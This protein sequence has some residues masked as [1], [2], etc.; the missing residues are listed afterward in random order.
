[1]RIAANT[2]GILAI[3]L[4]LGAGVPATAQSQDCR[5]EVQPG[6]T[7]SGIA[8]DKLGDALA[9]PDILALN[10]TK[11][12]EEGYLIYP[13]TVLILCADREVGAD[14]CEQPVARECPVEGDVIRWTT[15]DNYAPFTINDPQRDF[16]LVTEVVKTATCRIGCEFRF[17]FWPW[18]TARKLVERAPECYTGTFPWYK[19]PPRVAR[20]YKF[21]TGVTT[22]DIVAFTQVDDSWEFESNNYDSL[23][24]KDVCRPEGYFMDDLEALIDDGR[25]EH[26]AADTLNDCFDLLLEGEVDV[27]SVGEQV[28]LQAV[29]ELGY[30]EQIRTSDATMK[31]RSL[32]MMFHDNAPNAEAL[33]E[34]LDAE[35]E[36]MRLDGTIAALVEKHMGY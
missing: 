26:T 8:K 10:P 2:V 12:E 24:G 18:A 1:M 22:V 7:L 17:E 34:A 16:G 35:M 19:T 33:I 3:G 11:V 29:E 4:L 30:S 31:T 28:G 32:R 9:W 21:S 14:P 13:G 27:V 36:A 6:D 5:Y 25:I 15:G 20:D 23:E